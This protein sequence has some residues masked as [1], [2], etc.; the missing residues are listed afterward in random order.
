M[1]PSGIRGRKLS[2]SKG[3]HE[4]TASAT[5]LGKGRANSSAGIIR[6][7][8]ES[9]IE[10]EQVSDAGST[11]STAAKNATPVTPATSTENGTVRQIS[12]LDKLTGGRKKSD[13]HNV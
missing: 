9:G 12:W 13:E 6:P 10:L 5:T 7:Q 1:D 11:N 3:R 4:S 8:P 2:I